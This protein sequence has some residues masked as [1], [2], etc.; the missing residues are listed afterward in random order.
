M[1]TTNSVISAL[2][3]ASLSLAGMAVAQ[4]QSTN[5]WNVSAN[6]GLTLSRGN[7]RSTQAN[8][9]VN[10]DTK[11]DANEVMLGLSAGYGK[12]N[13]NGTTSTTTET[14]DGVGQFNHLFNERLYGGLKVDLYHD[15]VA[16]IRYRLSVSPML[17]YYFI[18]EA[19]TSLAGE[20]GPGY[21]YANQGGV[22]KSYL[23][24]RLADRFEHK[25]SDAAK[26]WQTAEILPQID[27]FS[28]YLFNFE[29][30]AEAKMTTH[31]SLRTVFDDHYNSKPSAGRLKNDA[32][33]IAGVAYKF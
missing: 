13:I 18:K 31:L 16:A 12:A 17:G 32:I 5:Q 8:A 15:G 2:A 6:A 9:G 1:R 19:N 11:W 3:V 24:L 23:T 33:I 14:L 20:V 10:A 25:F 28:N 7:S 4:A 26:I 27:K 21:V 22:R 29:L 30:G